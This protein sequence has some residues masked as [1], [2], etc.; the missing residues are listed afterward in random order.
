GTGAEAALVAGGSLDE[1]QRS[2]ETCLVSVRQPNLDET[3]P[4]LFQHANRLPHAALDIGVRAIEWRGRDADAHA[5]QTLG[6][7]GPDI[8]TR[9][10]RA[11]PIPRI[12]ARNRPHTRPH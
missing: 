1:M 4:E 11:R 6:V 2:R 7:A 10:R 12:R 8:R 5:L 3:C 9:T